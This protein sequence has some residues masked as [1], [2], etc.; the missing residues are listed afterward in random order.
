MN[1][2]F[3]FKKHQA[4]EQLPSVA[5]H[6]NELESLPRLQ[7]ISKGLVGTQLHQNVYVF[8]IVKEVVE[9]DNVDVLQHFMYFYF[10]H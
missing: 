3:R 7:E 6:L 4:Q 5:L 2:P 8:V 9:L 10:A 1:D